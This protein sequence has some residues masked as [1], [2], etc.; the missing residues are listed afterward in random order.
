VPKIPPLPRPRRWRRLAGGAAL[1]SLS[2][3]LLLGLLE[4]G[5]RLAGYQPLF[6]V[7]SKP[8]LFWRHDP[9]LG[10]S[11]E[12]GAEGIYVGP[13]PWPI[14]FRAPVRINSLGLRGPEVAPL[15]PGGVRILLLGDSVV[16]G[17]EVAYE[18]T[19]GALLEGHLARAL[20]VPVQVVNA[21]VRGYGTDQSLLYF[22]EHGRLLEPD[23]VVSFFS[24]N[25]PEDNVTLHRMRRPF[26]KA[27]FAPTPGGG[28]ELRGHPIPTYPLC[29]AVVLDAGYQPVR[30]DGA[31]TRA[32]CWVETRLSDHS[33]LF[34]W[35][36]LRIRRN[37]TL[38][39]MLY[40]L[41]SPEQA[42]LPAATRR[43]GIGAALASLLASAPGAASSAAEG[44]PAAAGGEQ[45]PRYR[46][47]S[48]ILLAL[49]REV[50]A[51]GAELV[52]VA[53]RR[54]WA[55]LD[56]PALRAEGV[57]LNFPEIAGG[58]VASRAVHFKNDAHLNEI[59]HELLAKLLAR[60]LEPL[61]RAL[62]S[63]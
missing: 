62:A 10:W 4:A 52:I 18:D 23:L 61:V 54:E 24:Y 44:P 43:A 6:E 5:F 2:T 39:R 60:D 49:A 42:A 55:R 25:D 12:P 34:T 56:Q 58:E 41:G 20:G 3:L 19:F 21:G 51:A 45:D 9:L 22:R 53:P 38:L 14:E 11:H 63:R 48:A 57:A 40:G 47:T 8:S 26:G 27:A 29:S 46:L 36:A 50:R 33:A 13:R 31:H 30:L 28:L 35:M 32:A 1:A 16:V 7:Y 17:F 37:P 15:P 59:G